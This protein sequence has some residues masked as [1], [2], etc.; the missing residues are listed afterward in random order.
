MSVYPEA[1]T[2]P[3][4]TGSISAAEREL[5][6]VLR[7]D[8]KCV[9]V[10]VLKITSPSHSTKPHHMCRD[11]RAFPCCRHVTSQYQR[12]S[13][14]CIKSEFGNDFFLDNPVNN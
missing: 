3:R 8:L 12:E 7:R 4:E 11:I 1:F 13:A 9:G 14:L 2:S 6:A 10:S 5:V